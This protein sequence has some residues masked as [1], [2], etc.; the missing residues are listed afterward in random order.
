[1]RREFPALRLATGDE[2]LEVRQGSQV[3]F[4]ID[5]K[6][7]GMVVNGQHVH[8]HRDNLEDSLELIWQL[9]T[10]EART[11]EEFRDTELAA[12]WLEFKVG[13]AFE[14]RDLA[15]YLAPSDEAEGTT[16]PGESC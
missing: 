12:T 8:A 14:Q 13:E 3:I 9:L 16:L 15:A 7:Q 10:G 1:L 2:C 4:S 11:V 5:G 6:S